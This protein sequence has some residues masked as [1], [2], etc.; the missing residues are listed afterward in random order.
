MSPDPA[1]TEDEFTHGSDTEANVGETWMIYYGGPGGPY[2]NLSVANREQVRNQI[3]TDSIDVERMI[4]IQSGVN[5]QVMLTTAGDPRDLFP[6][7]I[8]IGPFKLQRESFQRLSA[9]GGFGTQNE[10]SQA[11]DTFV[12]DVSQPVTEGADE[13]MEEARELVDDTKKTAGNAWD[14][15]VEAFDLGAFGQTVVLTG[16]VAVVL[17]LLNQTFDALGVS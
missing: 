9:M 17:W 5:V 14:A 2:R 3:A 8:H 6:P 15:V 13:V 4:G 12:R 7:S 1:T 11:I 16:L 10:A